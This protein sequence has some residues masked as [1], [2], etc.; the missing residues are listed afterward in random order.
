[1]IDLLSCH[2][3]LVYTPPQRVSVNE[4]LWK[5]PGRWQQVVYIPD[6][7]VCFRVKVYKL[8]VNEDKMS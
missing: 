2:F 7:C 5:F 8:M 3:S 4:S 6:K 1:M